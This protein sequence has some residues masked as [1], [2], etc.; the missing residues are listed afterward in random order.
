[1]VLLCPENTWAIVKTLGRL[2]GAVCS[3][4]RHA[5][6]G[7][8]EGGKKTYYIIYIMG[9]QSE[10][11]RNHKFSGHTAVSDKHV[12]Y[13][14]IYSKW[15]NMQQHIILPL[16]QVPSW[17]RQFAHDHLEHKASWAPSGPGQR[18][19]FA[20]IQLGDDWNIVIILLSYICCHHMTDNAKT[21]WTYMIIYEHEVLNHWVH[22]ARHHLHL[23]SG[24][25]T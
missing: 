20:N 16:Q 14:L 4:R 5:T 11:M 2:W 12:T 24:N 17:A 8:F 15:N 19:W 13:K 3:Q 23:P 7:G 10:M 22:G 21:I 1:M 25:L 18:C 6:T 9:I